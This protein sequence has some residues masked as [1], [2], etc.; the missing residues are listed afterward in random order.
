MGKHTFFV[1]LAL[2]AVW[3][4]LMEELSW[5]SVA[6][7]MISTMVALHIVNKFLPYDEIRNINFL[8]LATYPLFLLGQIYMAGFQVIGVILRGSVVD[9][10]TV[11]TGIKDESLRVIL[12]DSITLTPG[13][14]LLGL[15]EQNITLLWIRDKFTPG[16]AETASK[17]LKSKLEAR[18]IKADKA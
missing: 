18:L 7:G 17:L 13:S 9:I 12:A 8:K 3:I 6:M 5:R 10:V 14:I 4:I 2:T 16:D 1:Q 11:K 15:E